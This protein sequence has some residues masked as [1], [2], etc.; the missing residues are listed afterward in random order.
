MGFKYPTAFRERACERMLAGE[1]ADDLS[2][3]LDLSAGTLYRWKHQALIG[4]GLKP[5]RRSFEP[6]ELERVRGT[7]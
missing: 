3:E 7:R 2:A 5:G 6:D 1:R 4:A